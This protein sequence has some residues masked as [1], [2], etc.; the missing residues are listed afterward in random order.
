MTVASAIPAWTPHP[1][2][3]L[4]VAALVV[5]YAVAVERVGPRYARPGRPAVSRFQLAC[6]GLGVVAL[7]VAADWPIHDTAEQSRYSVHMVQHLTFSMVSA[8]LL[9]LGTPAWMLRY[10][11]RPPSRLFRT[12][13]WLARFLPA[14]IVYNVV[15]VVTHWPVLVNHSLT[16]APLHFTLHSVLFLSSLI[17]W[18]PVLSP[19]PEL[20]RLPPLTR[21]LFLFAWSIVP[22]VPASFLTFGAHPLYKAYEHLPKLW[23]ATAL[24]DQQ[25]A[26]LLMKLG[27]GLLLW[28]LIAVIFFRWAAEEERRNH[29]QMRREM[30]R[31]L[32][33][34]GL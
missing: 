14:L 4:L 25:I 11:L 10:I 3:W 22:T 8:P 23:G 5:G 2:V 34:M 17:I 26:G 31:E 12:V 19:M 27:A 13:R 30:E 33:Q 15:L 7:W 24:E 32:S 20:P 1:D 6:F 9:L 16:S 21:S 29:P 28:A 18:L